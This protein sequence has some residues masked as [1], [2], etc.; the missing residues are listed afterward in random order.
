MGLYKTVTFLCTEKWASGFAKQCI[1]LS[2]KNKAIKW[3]NGAIVLLWV[4]DMCSTLL[5][6]IDFL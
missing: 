2:I 6:L 1:S 5:S 4:T 3:Q